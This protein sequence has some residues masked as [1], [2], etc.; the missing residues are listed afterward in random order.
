MDLIV[1]ERQA[2][3]VFGRRMIGRAPRA[4]VFALKRNAPPVAVDV[5]FEDRCVMDQPIHGGQRHRGIRE[6]LAPGTERLVCGDEGGTA[7]VPRRD[8]FEQN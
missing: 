1:A 8:Q 7:F 5:D 3:R 4:F 2:N 6:N